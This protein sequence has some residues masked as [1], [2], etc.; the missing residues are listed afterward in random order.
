M[1][2]ENLIGKYYE[3]LKQGNQGLTLANY[4]CELFEQRTTNKLI[5]TM[6]RLLKIYSA[7]IILHAITDISV[8]DDVDYGG[9]ILPLLMYFC[10][11]NF[12]M[13]NKDIEQQNYINTKK[14]RSTLER[15]SRRKLKIKDPFEEGEV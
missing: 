7:D 6:N 10:K 4:Y 5:M 13:A 11:K 3:L 15:A 8:M 14:L 1:D 9:N 12:M 2:S